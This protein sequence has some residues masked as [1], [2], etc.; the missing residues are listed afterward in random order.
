MVNGLSEAEQKIS[1]CS[2]D[3]RAEVVLPLLIQAGGIPLLMT[4][5]YAAVVRAG[6]RR[7]IAFLPAF[8]VLTISSGVALATVG[9]FLHLEKE[10]FGKGVPCLP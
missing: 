4:A 8:L 10:V 1:A 6:G 7:R 2:I 5:T 3:D 9:F